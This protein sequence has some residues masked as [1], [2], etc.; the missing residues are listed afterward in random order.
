MPRRRSPLDLVTAGAV[1]VAVHATG[2]FLLV[3]FVHLARLTFSERPS[4]LQALET[5]LPKAELELPEIAIES[6]V[7]GAVP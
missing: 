5:Q 7:V 4:P 6:S 3:G 2:A 1:S